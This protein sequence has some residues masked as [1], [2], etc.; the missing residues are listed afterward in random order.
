ML[1]V[2]KGSQGEKMIAAQS[3]VSEQHF[4]HLI[5]CNAFLII[6]KAVGTI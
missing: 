2:K 4:L 6:K 1:S 5:E 3:N